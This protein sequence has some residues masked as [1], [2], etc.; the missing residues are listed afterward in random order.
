DAG[1]GMRDAPKPGKPL[2]V[3][4]TAAD[5][6]E[7]NITALKEA[8]TRKTKPTPPASRIPHPVPKGVLIPPIEL[9]N[10]APPQAGA[11]G[12]AQIEQMGPKRTETLQTFRVR[13]PTAGR[14]VGPSV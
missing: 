10:P 5:E 3:P 11:A 12:L 9:L 1:S 14:T 8:K 13:G 6:R 7:R 4:E 2:R